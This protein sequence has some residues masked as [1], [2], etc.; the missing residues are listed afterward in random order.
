MLTAVELCARALLKLGAAPIASFADDKAEAMLAQGLY[1]SV[2]NGLLVQYPWRFAV[3]QMA[4]A[5]LQTAPLSEFTYAFQLPAD[6]LRALNVSNGGIYRI[7]RHTLHSHSPEVLL[8]YI[9]QP[10]E[11]YFPAHFQTALVARLAA[12]FCL[13]LTENTSRA[14]VLMRHAEQE[15]AKAKRVDTQQDIPQALQ[16]FSLINAREGF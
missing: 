4:L 1:A 15:F 3:A 10:D 16:H 13:P 11:S 9:Y 2:R 6:F 5:P 7:V 14:D 8:S 12:E